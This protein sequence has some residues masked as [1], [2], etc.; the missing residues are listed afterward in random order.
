MNSK[1][2]RMMFRG[3]RLL[4]GPLCAA[5]LLWS[6]S[7]FAGDYRVVPEQSVFAVVVHKGGVAGRLAHDHFIAAS[8]YTAR[9]EF[10]KAAPLATRFEIR[11]DT[12]DL[13][14]D[15][16]E[17]SSKWYPR[18]EV[19]GI[20]DSPFPELSDEDRE[21]IRETM[22]SDKQLDAVEFPEISAEISS[23]AE[24]IKEAG[25]V[26]FSHRVALAL[27]ARGQ[28]VEKPM[29]ARYVLEGDTLHVE[30]FGEF[31]FRDFGI[32]PY[33]AMLGMVK[34]KDEFHVYV[35]LEAIRSDE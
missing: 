2:D 15:R 3:S 1:R 28:T 24:E 7:A 26:E 11:F 14:V 10:S 30:A 13:V 16:Q 18:L 4:W 19:L 22:L 35:A 33:S 6:A 21:K 23:I 29:R 34:V 31:R 32:K 25:T 17:W 27:S 12:E 9:V 5:L 8:N 20:L